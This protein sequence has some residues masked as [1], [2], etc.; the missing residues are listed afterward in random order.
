MEIEIQKWSPE[1]HR[2]YQNLYYRVMK[3]KTASDEEI[4][5]FYKLK[6]Q[7]PAFSHACHRDNTWKGPQTKGLSR[8]EG[9]YII[10][11]D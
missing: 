3:T 1:F 9:K 10:S 7:Q 5:Y 8:K 6:N 11:F 2:I 4:Q